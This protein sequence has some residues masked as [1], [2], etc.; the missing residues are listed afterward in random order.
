MKHLIGIVSYGNLPFLELAIRG[1]QETLTRPADVLVIIARPNDTEMQRFLDERHVPW[2]QNTQNIGF[3]GS[4]NDIFEFGWANGDYDTITIQ[5]NDV[6]PYPGALDGM[7]EAAESTDWEWLCA[8]QFDS[9]SLVARYPEARQFFHGDNLAFTDFTSR[10]W[11]MHKDFRTPHIEPDSLKDVRNLAMFKRSVYEKTGYADVNF[12]PNSYFEDNDAARRANI[13][14]VKSCG[15]AHCAYFHFWSRTIHQG[16]N[17][18]HGEYYSRNGGHYVHK[19]GGPVGGERYELPYDGRGFQL[20]PEIFL[21]PKLK[22]DS[23]AQEEAIIQYW[24]TR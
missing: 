5:G 6:I 2:I 18:A 20:S 15:L 3:A 24:S 16:E 7:I 23:R 8:S 21:E 12:W 13:A 22:I 14:G 10:P 1:I 19:W 4:I 9:K 17:R 11:E